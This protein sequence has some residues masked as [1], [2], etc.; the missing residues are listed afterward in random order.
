MTQ[1]SLLHV[2]PALSRGG[3]GRALLTALAARY[4]GAPSHDRVVSLAAADPFMVE[5]AARLG[6][7]VSVEPPTEDLIELL[8]TW[9]G[10]RALVS[11]EHSAV[12]DH[13]VDDRAPIGPVGR[14][15]GDESPELIG[16]GRQLTVSGRRGGGA[17][18]DQRADAVGELEREQLR[19]RS[20]G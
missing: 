6:V 11:R 2:V 3:A 12:A 13:V 5:A 7:T 16:W 17:D 8:A 10:Y 20:A 14:G 19:E 15:G 18:Q 9:P 1:P 4:K